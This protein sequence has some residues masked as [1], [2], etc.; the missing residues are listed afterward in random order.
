MSAW[1]YRSNMSTSYQS[2]IARNGVGT[3]FEI[4]T[5]NNLINLYSNGGLQSTVTIQSGQRYHIAVVKDTAGT[6]LYVNGELNNSNTF[7]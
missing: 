7:T 3:S 4:S 2:I 5:Y 6:K 1:I